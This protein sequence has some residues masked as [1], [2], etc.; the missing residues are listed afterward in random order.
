MSRDGGEF[1][2]KFKLNFFLAFAVAENALKILLSTRCS[3]LFSVE[4]FYFLSSICDFPNLQ[5]TIKHPVEF[6]LSND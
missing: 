4:A 6:L 3:Q 5:S 1:E 2:N